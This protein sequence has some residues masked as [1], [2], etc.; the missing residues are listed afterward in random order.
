VRLLPCGAQGRINLAEAI[1]TLAQQGITRL[2]IEAGAEL[3]TAFLQ[4]GLVD[5]M[6]WFRAPL[7]IGNDGLAAF[8]GGLVSELA[9]AAR[10]HVID[11]MNLPPDN[12]EILE[13][14]PAS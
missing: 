13:C 4:S 9:D 1:K 12:L 14:L 5:R 2:F 8:T 10:W 11:Q 7:V 6:Y 3:S